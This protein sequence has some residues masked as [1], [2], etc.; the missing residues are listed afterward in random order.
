[1]RAIGPEV[2]D[3]IPERNKIESPFR[4]RHPSS[5]CKKENINKTAGIE[6]GQAH[7]GYV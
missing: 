7:P 4:Y 3:L 6:T 5:P 2:K 1:M